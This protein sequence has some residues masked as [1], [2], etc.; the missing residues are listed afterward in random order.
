MILNHP[1]H[2]QQLTAAVVAFEKKQSKKRRASESRIEEEPVPKIQKLGDPNL[3]P[4]T[5]N[6]AEQY[7][8]DENGI[9]AEIND[10]IINNLLSERVQ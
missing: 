3:V 10:N 5:S 7:A 6:A 4:T 9:P 8:T 2:A 1:E